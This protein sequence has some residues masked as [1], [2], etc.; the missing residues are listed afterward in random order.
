MLSKKE[1]QLLDALAP[2]AERE[3]VE[4]VTVEV[5]G[6]KKAPTIRVFID[7]PDGVSFDELSSAQAWIN[8]LM[9]ELDPFPGAYTLEVSSPGIDRPLRTVEHFARFAGDTAVLKT[10]PVD[11]RSS[12]TGTIVGAEGDAVTLDV[13]GAEVQIPMNTIKRA[14]LKGTIDFSSQTSI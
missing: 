6:A 9:D 7:T 11:G 3:G 8:D 5:A 10:Q 12:W 14:H 13:D 1:Q 2:R 4:V